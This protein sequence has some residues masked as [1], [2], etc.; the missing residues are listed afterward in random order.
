[1]NLIQNKKTS[2]QKS[3]HFLLLHMYQDVDLWHKNILPKN[4][5]FVWF[6]LIV[7]YII[8]IYSIPN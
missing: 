5:N 8:S 6:A 4:Q 1:M 2:F 3:K 7:R